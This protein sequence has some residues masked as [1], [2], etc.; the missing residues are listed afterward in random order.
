MSRLIQSRPVRISGKQLLE[1][2]R[3]RLPR[4]ALGAAVAAFGLTG[5]G[6]SEIIAYPYWCLE[7]GYA[8]VYRPQDDIE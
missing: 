8:I 4:E 3:F 2:V 5:V 7:K 1:G 6:A